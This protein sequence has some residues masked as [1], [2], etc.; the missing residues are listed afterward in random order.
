MK[1]LV[2]AALVLAGCVDV[3]DD[4]AATE[5]PVSDDTVFFDTIVTVNADGTTNVS[6]PRTITAGE[7]RAQ[8]ELRLAVERGEVAAPAANLVQDDS[9][10]GDSL[11]FYYRTD[12]VGPRIC[13]RGAGYADLAN[14]TVYI[15]VNGHPFPVG[16]WRIQ[17]GSYW[18]GSS[19][20]AIHHPRS[21][22]SGELSWRLSFGGWGA[23]QAFGQ[24][25]AAEWITLDSD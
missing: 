24:P 25:S 8:N 2:L 19:G 12:W 7:Q 6:E 14:Y 15:L 16:D 13:F 5:D 22:F 20:G 23:R 9:C 11:W 10:L 21:P 1:H 4:P 3:P 18:P 17:S